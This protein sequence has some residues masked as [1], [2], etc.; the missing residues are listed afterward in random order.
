MQV[1]VGPFAMDDLVGRRKADGLVV[2]EPDH[3]QGCSLLHGQGEITP[4]TIAP[5][6]RRRQARCID[7]HQFQMLGRGPV[8]IADD[9]VRFVEPHLP[10]RQL[11]A[12]PPSPQ[13]RLIARRPL[14][15]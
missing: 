10:D 13:R 15:D 2:G 9:E 6:L 3:R 5:G 8:E 11:H 4:V 12:P 14:P 1:H 7:A